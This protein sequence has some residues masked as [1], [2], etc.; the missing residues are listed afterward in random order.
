MMFTIKTPEA[1]P[2]SCYMKL[3]FISNYPCRLRALRALILITRYISRELNQACTRT[4]AGV[5][6]DN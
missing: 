2:G 6:Y 3:F 4:P 5:E 1:I